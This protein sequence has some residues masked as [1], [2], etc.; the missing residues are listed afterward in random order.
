MERL[1]AWVSAASTYEMSG[2]RSPTDLQT[3]TIQAT[4]ALKT[5]TWDVPPC[6]TSSLIGI[7]LGGDANPQRFARSLGESVRGEAE[8]PTGHPFRGSSISRHPLHTGTSSNSLGSQPKNLSVQA[9]FRG[10]ITMIA[11]CVASTLPVPYIGERPE[12]AR[13]VDKDAAACALPEGDLGNPMRVQLHEAT[14]LVGRTCACAGAR[15]CELQ[16]HQES[17]GLGHL[18]NCSKGVPAHGPS[19]SRAEECCGKP[20]EVRGCEVA[21]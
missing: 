21:E 14:T 2:D 10:H 6:T 18:K 7:V 16:C 4:E 1:K 11:T 20:S 3:S 12:W 8:T 13:R 15:G 9:V 19:S 17:K 5:E